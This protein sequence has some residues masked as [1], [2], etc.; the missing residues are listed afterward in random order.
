MSN[1]DRE[2]HLLGKS[3]FLGAS[4]SW[5][6]N[7]NLYLSA[8]YTSS[9]ISLDNAKSNEYAIDARYILTNGKTL[10]LKYC[11]DSDNRGSSFLLSYT[12][13]FGLPIVKKS[14]VG[15]IK[16]IIY[17]AEQEKKTGIPNVILTINNIAAVTD[18]DGRYT[19]PL[20]PTG[21]Y[22]LYVD[23]QSIGL[24]HVT[25]VEDSLTVEVKSGKAT[26]VNIGVI[27][28]ASLTGSVIVVDS[29][30]SIDN[31][32][33]VTGDPKLKS[34]DKNL[35]E[36]N[37]QSKDYGLV[38]VLVELSNGKDVIRRVTDNNGLFSFE[39]LRPGKWHL[40]VYEDNL[41]EYH[42]LENSSM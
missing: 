31:N 34:S 27:A 32:L 12:I 23:H 22:S 2:S 30:L 38:N 9:N 4:A 25:D 8:W 36:S 6:P 41:P 28:S 7:D 33:F 35:S 29:K 11:P 3:N 39:G 20:F 40:K 18:H 24:N 10:S 17:S 19:F 37:E 26:E 42:Y 5:Q 15:F 21:T 14:K 1:T 16:G 13:P